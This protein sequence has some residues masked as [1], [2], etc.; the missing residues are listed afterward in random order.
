MRRSV[1]WFV[2]CWLTA[3]SLVA[4]EENPPA[5]RP[6]RVA[7]DY[8]S[9]QA[10][11]DSLPAAGGTVYIPEG[12][13]ALDQALDLTRR[14]YHVLLREEDKQAG[15]KPRTNSYV[16]L[17]GAGNGTILEGRMKNGPVI[18]LTDSSFCTLSQLQIRSQTAQCGILLARPHPKNRKGVLLSCGWHTFYN[19][20]IGGSYSVAAVYNQASEVDRWYGCQ[21]SNM[22]PDAHCFV[23]TYRNFA[24]LVSPYAGELCDVGSNSDQRFNGCL[25]AHHAGPPK[26]RDNPQG[27]TLYVQGWATDF[28][29]TD[30][31]FGVSGV[32]AAV[33]LDGERNP[34]NGI[35][36]ANNRFENK[37][38]YLVLATGANNQVTFT[39]NTCPGAT[40]NFIRADGT[41]TFWEV[42]GNQF[43][44]SALP[45]TPPLLF[46][47]LKDSVIGRN[48]CVLAESP[49]KEKQTPQIVVTG[50]CEASEIVV[51]RREDFQGTAV[52]T[53]L[54][55]TDDGGAR[56]EYLGAGG[57]DV[58]LN[59][60]PRDTR[61]LP[62]PKRGDVALDDGTNT[63][64][65][66]PALAVFDGTEWRYMD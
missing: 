21:F 62:N 9:I 7:T 61:K 33:W 54:T 1:A 31:D 13:Y 34:N 60:T 27:A 20:N 58:V 46:E 44:R 66:K 39:G 64:S 40:R 14:N 48:W 12:R 16:H 49:G 36:I 51:P 10:A 55:A 3:S 19:V 23:F 57:G 15:R 2:G 25:F 35:H 38:T 63:P 6:F 32:K 29:V 26:D 53:R 8:P 30:C 17:L 41:A 5:L 52:R 65:K 50:T 22:H 59:F 37:A 42:H 47:N 11:I 18:D 24:G 43:V 56:R 4:A 45:D 28:A